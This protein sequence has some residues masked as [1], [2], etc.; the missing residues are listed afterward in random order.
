LDWLE[1]L[2]FDGEFD[3][4]AAET[5][6][7]ALERVALF[8]AVFALSAPLI[9]MFKASVWLAVSLTAEAWLWV[10]TSPALMARRPI[11]ARALRLFGSFAAVCNWSAIGV[12]FWLSHE[13]SAE[14][15]GVALMAGVLIYVVKACYRTPLHLLVCF[16]PPATCLAILPFSFA[17][18]PTRAFALWCA[19]MLLVGFS[20]MSA[21]SACKA[22]RGLMI[23]AR[24]LLLRSEAADAANRAKSEFLANMSHEIRTPLNGVLGMAQAMARDDLPDAQRQRLTLIRQSG[25]TLLALLNDLLDLSKIEA[26]KIELEDSVVDM[27]EMARSAQTAFTTL[28][29]DKDLYL[30]V[31][32]E[33]A[34]RGRWRGDATRVRQILYNLVSNAVKFTSRGSVQIAVAHDGT[35]LILRVSDTGAGIPAD[36][37]AAL[38][39]KF[40]QADASTT[41]KFGGTGLGLSISRELAQLMGGDIRVNSLE[42]QGSTFIVNLPLAR[43]EDEAAPAASAAALPA[44]VAGLRILVA[45]DNPMNQMVLK[46]LMGQVGVD[47]HVVPDGEQAVQAWETGDWDVVLMDVQMPVLDGP[48]A[49]RRI[50]T[51]E[52]ETGRARTPIIALTANTMAHHAQEYAAAGMDALVPKP[53]EFVRLL[54]TIDAVLASDQ[55]PPAQ[56]AVA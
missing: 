37:L 55:A 21:I 20:A 1:R 17:Y 18:D 15:M 28:A 5:R 26:G 10:T 16:T 45:E 42:G 23:A 29:S 9:G 35:D 47:P 43:M 56:A 51:R 25:E 7:K 4:M 46:T 52:V 30:V 33:P 11:L 34:A 22:H 49:A 2:G 38:F 32:V 31:E 50:R 53:L 24:E 41:R 39:D 54:E 8:A 48:S 12:L 6:A 14:I 19:F 40:V 27:A 36:R 3:A 44:Q 13:P